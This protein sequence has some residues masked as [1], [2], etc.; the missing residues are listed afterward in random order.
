MPISNHSFTEQGRA[1]SIGGASFASADFTAAGAGLFSVCLLWNPAASGKTLFV[2]K[3]RISASAVISFRLCRVATIMGS[4]IFASAQ[5]KNIGGAA[6]VAEVRTVSL[7]GVGVDPI[8][9]N[10]ILAAGGMGTL[11][12]DDPLRI[13]PGLGVYVLLDVA[14]TAIL[15]SFEWDEV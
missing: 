14:N 6:G 15:S 1:R 10:G 2:K 8:L 9:I 13:G 7:G 5:N 12:F 11:D 4:A 3:I